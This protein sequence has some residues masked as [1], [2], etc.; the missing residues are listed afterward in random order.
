MEQKPVMRAELFVR[1]LRAS[2]NV[3]GARV[4]AA[5]SRGMED[6]DRY[7]SFLLWWPLAQF[8]PRVWFT[9]FPGQKSKPSGDART[10]PNR[11][12]TTTTFQ[13]LYRISEFLETLNSRYF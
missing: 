2:Q 8:F 4:W 5:A 3:K 10:I 1:A 7:C 13:N 11:G 6:L 9:R 12:R